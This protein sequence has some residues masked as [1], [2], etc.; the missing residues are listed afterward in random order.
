M[1]FALESTNLLE[2]AGI[3]IV[4]SAIQSIF[5]VGILLFG[6][7][8]LLLM[9]YPFQQV[10]WI[11]LPVSLAVSL[12]QVFRGWKHIQWEIIVRLCL[13]TLPFTLLGTLYISQNPNIPY[14]QFWIALYL[15]IFT[16]G[17]YFNAF[18]KVIEKAMHRRSVYLTMCGILHGLTN[19]GGSLL[20]SFVIA[21]IPDKIQARSTIAVGYGLLVIVQLVTLIVVNAQSANH[22]GYPGNPSHWVFIPI[23]LLVFFVAD[24][25]VF[26]KFTNPQFKQYFG[27]ILLIISLM[28]MVRSLL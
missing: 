13:Y 12:V 25:R 6:T 18:P 22:S 11:V 17:F 28:L 19:L 26:S 9:G 24:K 15:L 8:L 10:L 16:I 7:P 4:V 3:L 27:P 5:G 2:I 1:P 23:A 21:K 14:L 20:S